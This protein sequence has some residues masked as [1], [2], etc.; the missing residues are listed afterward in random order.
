MLNNFIPC[1]EAGNIPWVIDNKVGDYSNEPD[2]VASTVLRWFEDKEGLRKMRKRTLALGRPEAT[3][4]IV[5]DLVD[6]VRKYKWTPFKAGDIN[7][8][9]DKFATVPF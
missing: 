2:Q 7:A 6:L 3:Y 9:L 8:E 4:K 5:D 1:Q